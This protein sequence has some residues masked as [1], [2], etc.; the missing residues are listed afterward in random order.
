MDSGKSNA[1]HSSGSARER[2]HH[3]VAVNT[4]GQQMR[5]VAQVLIGNNPPQ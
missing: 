4:D 5:L 2:E 1:A 3:L